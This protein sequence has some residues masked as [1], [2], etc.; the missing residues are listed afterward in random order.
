MFRSNYEAVIS[1]RTG[2]THTLFT[3]VPATYNIRIITDTEN[4]LY[5]E[6]VDRL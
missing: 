1:L 4:G 2:T 6:I 3:H 5:H